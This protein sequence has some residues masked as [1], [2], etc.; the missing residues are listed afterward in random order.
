[1]RGPAGTPRSRTTVRCAAC[2]SESATTLAADGACGK[3]RAQ[4]LPEQ[5]RDTLCVGPGDHVAGVLARDDVT[6]DRAR[7]R[8]APVVGAL[9]HLVP[10]LGLDDHGGAQVADQRP[11]LVAVE[12]V[13][14]AAEHLALVDL[15]AHVHRHGL[16][17]AMRGHAQFAGD[18]GDA[19]ARA[20]LLHLVAIEGEASPCETPE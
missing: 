19:I 10:A 14:V 6:R 5:L 11:S 15:A 9:A 13:D 7:P 16:A 8:A 12:R 4:V 1:M 18:V 17:D 2:A 3:R 20:E